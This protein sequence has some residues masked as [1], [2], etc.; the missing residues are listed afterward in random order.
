LVSNAIGAGQRRYVFPI[1]RR[2]A[3]LGAIIMT[4]IFLFTICFPNAI[5]SI[6]TADATLI[7]MSI[8]GLYI[9]SLATVLGGVSW[10]IFMTVSATGNPEIAVIIE[11]FTTV[12]YVFAIYTLANTFSDRI[13]LVWL[14]EIVYAV[15]MCAGSLIYLSTDHWKK[16]VI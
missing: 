5:L 7:E 3:T 16:K 6:Y 8:N 15:V 14:S 11:V 12:A 9:V 10:I 13:A 4:V 1:V 2:V